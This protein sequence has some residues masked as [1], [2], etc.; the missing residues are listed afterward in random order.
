MTIFDGFLTLE[1]RRSSEEDTSKAAREEI[2]K[3]LSRPQ[4]PAF[5]ERAAVS[6]ARSEGT[7]ASGQELKTFKRDG[8]NK[9]S[10]ETQETESYL[11]FTDVQD[12]I[13]NSFLTSK[14]TLSS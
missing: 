6:P 3:D 10:N 4:Q 1:T 5:D 2:R 7:V 13:C 14:R 9:K 8:H 11:V 12:L